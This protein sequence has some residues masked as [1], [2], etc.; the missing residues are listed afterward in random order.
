MQKRKFRIAAT[1]SALQDGP[2]DLAIPREQF[3]GCPVRK[4]APRDARF[5]L[6]N[7]NHRERRKMAG[8]FGNPPGAI[9]GLPG[10][11]NSPRDARFGLTNPNHRE[12][13]KMAG[14][15]GNH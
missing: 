1:I 10:S 14:G 2:G 8:G 15:F 12:R 4:T 11:E 7:P 9:Y 13:R 3:M 5:G 6:T